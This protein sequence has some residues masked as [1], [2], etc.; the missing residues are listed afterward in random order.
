LVLSHFNAGSIARSAGAALIAVTLSFALPT[1][2]SAHTYPG[3]SVHMGDRILREGMTGHDVRVLQDFLTRAGIPTT[4][5][6]QF[7]PGTRTNV[8]AF[9]RAH[10]LTPNGIVTYGVNLALR[11]AAGTVH[12]SVQS[13]GPAGRA[14]V[15]HGVATPPADAPAAIRAVIAAGNRIAFKPYIFG[16]GHGSWNDSGYDCSGSVGY[17]LHGGGLLS[18]TEDSGQF[19]SYG[20]TGRGHW[21]S[22]WANSGH[23]YM[24]VAGLR[25]DT[26]AQ[27]SGGSRWTTQGRSSAGYVVR[28]PRGY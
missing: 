20:A 26:S 27:G 28:H 7:G 24:Y 23:V 16:G 25:F 13:S 2:A 5:D 8:I 4:V 15:S 9:Q 11:S 10:H 18:S 12:P 6:G 17:A 1:M 14:T 22:I 21:I 3:D 19:E